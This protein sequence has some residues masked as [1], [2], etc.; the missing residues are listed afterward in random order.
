[1]K[2]E[3]E[4]IK[5]EQWYNDNRHFLNTSEICRYL[6]IDKANFSRWVNNKPQFNGSPQRLTN[7]QRVKLLEIKNKL[8]K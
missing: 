8:R 6:G 2:T 4:L 3:R 1:M 7:E 5:A